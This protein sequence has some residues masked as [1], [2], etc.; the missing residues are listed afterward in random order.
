[1]RR[2]VI[3]LAASAL[4]IVALTGTADASPRGGHGRAAHGHASY[5]GNGHRFSGGYYYRGRDQHHWTR[6]VWDPVC[7]RYQY[8]DPDLNVWYYWA[9]AYDCYYPITYTPAP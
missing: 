4:G 7:H 8:W 5:H 1:M 9:P 6:T 2:I 3:G